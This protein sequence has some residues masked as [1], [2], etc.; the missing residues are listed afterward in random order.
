MY[1][2]SQKLSVTTERG[3][4]KHG[5]RR[6]AGTLAALF[7]MFAA[8]LPTA[9]ENGEESFPSHY[10]LRDYGYVTPV[11]Y[12]NPWGT[13]WCFGGVAAVETSILSL[14]G[15]TY[16][17]TG[18]DL[19]ERH[20]VWFSQQT[21]TEQEAGNQAGEGIVSFDQENPNSVFRGQFTTLMTG[22]FA[23]GVGPV[24]EERFPYRGASGMTEYEFATA[25][26]ETV[27]EDAL[28]F[29]L[30]EYGVSTREELEQ[31]LIEA[32]DPAT[33]DELIDEFYYDNV[34]A[35]EKCDNY[36][37][38]DDWSIPAFDDMG[39][40]NRNLFYHWTLRDGNI[41]PEFRRYDESGN[42]VLNQDAIAAVKRE[43]MQ[44]HGVAVAF[45]ADQ[46]LP[47]QEAD[48]P[49]FLNKQTYAHYTYNNAMSNHEVCIVGWDDS[50]SRDNFLQGK[51]TETDE[52]GVTTTWDRTPPA[53]GAWIVKNSWGSETEYKT[54]ESGRRIGYSDWGF[55]NEE[56]LHTGYF[57]LSY[58]DRSINEPESF[59]FDS[60]LD[61][62][63]FLTYQSDYLPAYNGYYAPAYVVPVSMGNVFD[64]HENGSLCSVSIVSMYPNA[65]VTWNIYRMRDGATVPDDGELLKTAEATFAYAGFHRFSLFEPISI[66]KGDRIGI[67]ARIVSE[68]ERETSYSIT[69][70]MGVGKELAK[71]SESEDYC[72]A[73]VN[74]GESF[75]LYE[76]KWYDWVD[77][78]ETYPYAEET[79][80]NGCVIDNP[81]VKLFVLPDESKQIE[82]V[83][84]AAP[85]P[86]NTYRPIERPD[87]PLPTAA[88]QN[89]LKEPV[90]INPVLIGILITVGAGIV[91]AVVAL[92]LAMRRRPQ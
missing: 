14:M 18:L 6:I 31:M 7:L 46:S 92:L 87:I 10:D 8:V 59:A 25:Y 15:K 69:A 66:Q 89:E 64:I 35:Y 65:H 75:L 27:K 85:E 90:E 21:V 76:D 37:S 78:L 51:V 81:A 5:I 38:Y 70:S 24:G 84:T 73:V 52:D 28:N 4:M 45:C 53:D 58:Y 20:A 49:D 44:G 82:V 34:A 29:Y 91:A 3:Y 42:N 19:S 72:I 55:C 16:A 50:Y 60:D 79:E 86:E 36:T 47:G 63:R 67:V 40:S 62:T 32:G 57:Y 12:Q 56:G 26:P 77:Y 68:D 9:A 43:L 48:V 74:R 30:E 88:P 33:V 41:L 1:K 13:C 11:K 23:S 71:A 22:L 54:T 17:E 39:G 2:M 61:G 83:E 80:Y